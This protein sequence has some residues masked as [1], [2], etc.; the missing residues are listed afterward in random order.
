MLPPTA[1]RQLA[2]G[3]RRR[4]WGIKRGVGALTYATY[5]RL[6]CLRL[7][8]TAYTAYAQLAQSKNRYLGVAKMTTKRQQIASLMEGHPWLEVQFFAR[9]EHAE[10]RSACW[11]FREIAT[12]KKTASFTSPDRALAYAQRQQAQ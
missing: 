3:G 6:H 10:C 11:E 7:H 5:T 9:G 12:R 4:R 2:Q 1:I 8:P